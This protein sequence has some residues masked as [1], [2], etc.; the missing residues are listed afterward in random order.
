MSLRQ[1]RARSFEARVLRRRL[2]FVQ[3]GWIIA[4]GLRSTTSH[5]TATGLADLHSW[6]GDGLRQQSVGASALERAWL[7]PGGDRVGDQR[8]V[9]GVA[10]DLDAGRLHFAVNGAWA[11]AFEGIAVPAS[12]S[13]H[14]TSPR[15]GFR[16]RSI[17]ERDATGE[18]QLHQARAKPSCDDV[19]SLSCNGKLGEHGSGGRR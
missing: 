6:A 11:C 14:L 18:G 9:V 12:V 16:R 8:N 4:T 13:R 19:T 3:L 2:R 15:S 5:P 7:C 1:D 17:K 10:A